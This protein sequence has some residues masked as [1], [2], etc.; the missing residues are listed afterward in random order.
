MQIKHLIVFSSLV[1]A[2]A[3]TLDKQAAPALTGPSELGLSLAITASPDQLPEDGQSTSMITVIARDA[4]SQP[5]SGLTLHGQLLVGGAPTDVKGTLSSQ[6]IST[7]STGKATVMFTAPIQAATDTGTTVLAVEFTPVGA[8]YAN[9]AP[10]AVDIGLS[11]PGT[12]SLPGPT[13]RFTFAS[14]PNGTHF[15]GSSS[16]AVGGRSIVSWEWDFGDGSAHGTGSTVDHAY[17][18]T[19]PFVVTLK[20]TDSAGQVGF[21]TQTIKF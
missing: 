19:G 3:C 15:D 6:T 18:S 13:A 21:A 14:G 20:V 16:V 9:D 11:L 2:G 17:S 5:V 1:L 10:H 8:N 12:I 7:D 4:N